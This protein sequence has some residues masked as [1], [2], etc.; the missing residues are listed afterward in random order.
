MK[1]RR[2]I[3]VV[4]PFLIV[5]A[6]ILATVALILTRPRA[7]RKHPEILP[8]LVEVF[9]ARTSSH[10]LTL[11]AHGTVT[12]KQESLISAD[13]G[14]RVVWINPHLV[15][16][17]RLSSGEPLLRIDDRDYAAAVKE[18]EARLARTRTQLS[19]E[20][21][22][23]EI[24]LREW[25]IFSSEETSP[26]AAPE[27][28]RRDPQYA[29]AQ[30]DFLAAE[31]ALNKARLDLER[32]V[33]KSPFDALV[34]EESAELGEVISPQAP[35]ATLVATDEYEV[36]L[37]VPVEDLPLLGFASSSRTS[38]SAS[39]TGAVVLPP[40]NSS[41]GTRRLRYRGYVKRLLGT[42]EPQGR[43]A[44]VVVGVP[45]P[46]RT[47][48]GIAFPLLL[49]SYA[50]VQIDAGRIDRAFAVPAKAL[51]ENHSLWLLTADNRLAV[52]SVTVAWQDGDTLLITTGLK[53][54]DRVITTNLETPIPG[55]PLRLAET[56]SPSAVATASRPGN[57][58]K[59]EATEKK[60]L[61]RRASP[62]RDKSS[63]SR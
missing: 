24:A 3:R 28:A 10:P 50:T 9:T 62:V 47:M 4:L 40:R 8:P 38:S 16:G 49:N 12:P 54:G 30:A 22:R 57:A 45:H 52:R 11:I 39:P 23:R 2:L 31:A 48:D 35:F 21:S 17:G 60:N 42:V 44:R 43:M 26:V 37:S 19:I 15:E 18:A 20:Q 61:R 59:R 6:G 7:P 53:E 51:R 63:S 29:Q 55:M 34:I 27:L 58:G 36:E 56:S 25:E 5:L 33:P 46:F 14:G 32:T 1:S 41:L 13:V